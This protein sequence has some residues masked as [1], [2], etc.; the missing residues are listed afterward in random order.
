MHREL[1]KVLDVRSV[2]C[3]NPEGQEVIKRGIMKICQILTINLLITRTS[4]LIIENCHFL[5]FFLPKPVWLRELI[6]L[7]W[8][9]DCSKI[10]IYKFTIRQFSS[11]YHFLEHED[12]TYRW[13][14]CSWIWYAS[15][16]NNNIYFF[17]QIYN[18]D[19]R[20]VNCIN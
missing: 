6:L 1:Q 3:N 12:I 15:F 9:L 7:L 5:C 2:L 8:E 17:W 14:V 13:Q 19:P 18:Y 11:S 20:G 4:S 16:V 10:L